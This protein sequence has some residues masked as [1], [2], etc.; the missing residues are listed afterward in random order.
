MTTNPAR[1]F[2]ILELEPHERPP[3]RCFAHGSGAIVGEFLDA[4]RTEAGAD[5]AGESLAERER[6]LDA[7]GFESL[8]AALDHLSRRMDA[9][10]ARRDAR[11]R[12][13][14]EAEAAAIQA[15][16][17]AMPDPDALANYGPDGS[18]QARRDPSR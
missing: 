2:A 17:D 12:A 9:F 13:E 4:K 3:E 10:E 11:R 18:L 6:R 1:S 7:R 8:N 15:A 16:L 14:A 5:A